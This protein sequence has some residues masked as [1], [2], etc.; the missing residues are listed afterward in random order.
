M[1][2]LALLAPL[3]LLAAPA[4]LPA[5]APSP[6]APVLDPCHCIPLAG[7]RPSSG[8]SCAANL[9]L[10]VGASSFGACIHS[11]DPYVCEME[12]DPGICYQSV[13]VVDSSCS[14]PLTTN[15]SMFVRCDNTKT[16][17]TYFCC[18]GGGGSWNWVM[19]CTDCDG[20]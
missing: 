7:L 6:G 14:P 11:H 18:S 2:R 9:T 10:A 16:S 5:A 12:E 15:D 17:S 13:T 8:A 3:C 19:R 4:P 20:N 1:L